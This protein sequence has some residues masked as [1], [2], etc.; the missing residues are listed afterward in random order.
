MAEAAFAHAQRLGQPVVA[1]MIDIGSDGEPLAYRSSVGIAE[2][3]PYDD[4]TALLIHADRAMYTAKQVR[5]GAW[6]IYGDA[7]G[8]EQMGTG[9]AAASQA[10]GTHQP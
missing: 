3:P 5:G 1:P 6:R 8:T 9:P 7:A 10:T 4:L 2:C